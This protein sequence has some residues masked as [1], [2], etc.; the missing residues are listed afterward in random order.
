MLRRKICSQL[1]QQR[2]LRSLQPRQF[3]GPPRPPAQSAAEAE[4]AAKQLESQK[5]INVRGH[6]SLNYYY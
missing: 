5:R 4:H 6:V 1:V 3:S 2:G